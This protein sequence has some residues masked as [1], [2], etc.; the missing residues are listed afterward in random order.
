MTREEERIE[1]IEKFALREA[2]RQCEEFID[3]IKLL[4]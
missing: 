4:L 3:D 2:L 1:Q